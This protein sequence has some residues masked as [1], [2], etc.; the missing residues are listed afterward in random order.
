MHNAVA[1][2]LIHLIKHISV[3]LMDTQVRWWAGVLVSGR[4]DKLHHTQAGLLLARTL[5]GEGVSP[6][7][8][9]C[10]WL[11]APPKFTSRKSL[12]HSIGKPCWSKSITLSPLP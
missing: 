1:L 2:T 12:K 10:C 11:P 9:E 3:G 8:M 7:R 4:R 6:N 5:S